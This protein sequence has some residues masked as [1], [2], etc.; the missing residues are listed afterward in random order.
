MR[1]IC[2][3]SVYLDAVH[4]VLSDSKIELGAQNM[5]HMPSGAYTGETSGQMLAD[6]GCRYVLLGHSERR[7]QQSE[8]GFTPIPR[9][10]ELR[11]PTLV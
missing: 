2:P 3:P 5:H 4:G 8:T 6:L 9:T 11:F 10:V 7:H 1:A